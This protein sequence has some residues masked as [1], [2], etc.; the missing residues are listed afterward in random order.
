MCDIGSWF[1]RERTELNELPCGFLFPLTFDSIYADYERVTCNTFGFWFPFTCL[2]S[3]EWLQSH[4]G[5]RFRRLRP[6]VDRSRCRSDCERD[7]VYV[8]TAQA[9]ARNANNLGSVAQTPIRFDCI[10]VCV[11]VCVLALYLFIVVERTVFIYIWHNARHSHQN[12][13]IYFVFIFPFQKKK[14]FNSSTAYSKIF[15]YVHLLFQTLESRVDT[16]TLARWHE[17][18]HQHRKFHSTL[19]DLVQCRTRK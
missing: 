14:R 6:L 16:R 17:R 19:F 7:R 8:R 3:I 9:G 13:F 15:F 4:T 11:C 10:D 2:H 5:D 18:T 1:S 12:V